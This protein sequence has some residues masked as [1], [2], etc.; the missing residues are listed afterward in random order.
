MSP[1][2]RPNSQWRRQLRGFFGDRRFSGEISA[3]A[4][5]RTADLRGNTK[6]SVSSHTPGLVTN[7]DGTVDV[8]F[9]PRAIPGTEANFIETGDSTGFELMFR[10]YGVGPEVMAKKWVLTDAFRV[11]AAAPA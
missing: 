5:R 4:L 6:Y 7:D 2:R 3:L 1:V 11:D 9:G 10:F 8:Y